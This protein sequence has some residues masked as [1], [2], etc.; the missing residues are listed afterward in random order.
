M[1]YT[2]IGKITNTHGIKGEVKVYPLTDDI[3]RFDL[4]EK[5]YIGDGKIQVQVQNVKYHKNLVILKFKEYSNI[6]E[7][8][9][10]KD[11]F[12]Y[13]DE[14]G[15]ID[16]PEDHFFIYEILNSKVFDK[17]MN[18][19]GTLTDVIQGPSNDVYVIKD[20]DSSKEYLIP[21]VKQFIKKVDI[22]DKIIVIDPIEGMLE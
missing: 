18:L 16:L 21:A 4:L 1:E 7:I 15:R 11:Y 9:G 22:E 20:E 17:D 3:K 10:F 12:I 8:K 13:V 6:N 14:E 5:A 19:I 2:I